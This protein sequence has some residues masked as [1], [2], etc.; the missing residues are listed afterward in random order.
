M[1]QP[2][3]YFMKELKLFRRGTATTLTPLYAGSIHTGFESTVA[4]HEEEKTDLNADLT[5]HPE[6][7]FFARAEGT[8][9][10]QQAMGLEMKRTTI[11]SLLKSFNL[12]GYEA[13]F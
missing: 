12:F 13:S 10:L 7:M 1:W 3:F 6:A 2:N 11:S 4:G 8:R 9:K 5:K